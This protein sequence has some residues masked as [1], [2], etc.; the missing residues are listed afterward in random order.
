MSGL[1]QIVAI[2]LKYFVCFPYDRYSL[3]VQSCAYD[4]AL[5]TNGGEGFFVCFYLEVV[6]IS[7]DGSSCAHQKECSLL[8]TSVVYFDVTA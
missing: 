3:A 1:H 8:S 2:Y 6:Q 7:L 5:V 4:S